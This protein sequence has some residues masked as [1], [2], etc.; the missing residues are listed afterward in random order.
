[1]DAS[2]DGRQ[3]YCKVTDKYGNSV[4]SSTA[5]ISMGAALKIT[6]QPKSVTVGSGEQAIVSVKAS[7]DGLTYKWY[8]AAKGS[9]SYTYTATFSGNTYSVEM[10]E[11]RAGRSVYCIVSDKYGNSVKSSVATLNME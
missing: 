5:T 6:S 3:V 9:S 1:M 8:W 2:R 4:E 11:S 7:G 10:N